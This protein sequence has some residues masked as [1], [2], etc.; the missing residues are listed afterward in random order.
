[1]EAAEVVEADSD[2]IAG[3]APGAAAMVKSTTFETSV[4]VV[5]LTFEVAEDAEPGI[6]TA[7]CT[8]PAVARFA[9]GTGAVSWPELTSVVVS[10]FPFHKIKAPVVNPEPFAV[11]VKPCPPTVAELGLMKVRTDEDVWMERLVL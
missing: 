2:E 11:I 3:D 6:C 10:A 4:V 1:M 8:V 7:T 5:L 9:A